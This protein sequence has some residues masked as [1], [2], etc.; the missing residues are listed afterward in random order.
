MWLSSFQGFFLGGGGIRGTLNNKPLAH[1]VHCY[2]TLHFKVPL[3]SAH[4]LDFTEARL[5]HYTEIVFSPKSFS[6]CP[7]AR[8]VL[9]N[10]ADQLGASASRTTRA[11]PVRATPCFLLPANVLSEITALAIGIS[12]LGFWATDLIHS[13]LSFMWLVLF[14]K[15]FIY[16]FSES[17]EGRDRGKERL[18]CE[19]NFNQLPLT[20]P[21]LGPTSQACILT[22]NRTS[23]LSACRTMPKQ[24]SYTSQ[25]YMTSFRSMRNIFP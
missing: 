18:V 23:N 9:C 1:S 5:E 22:G 2:G 6:R 12:G 10:E 17:G 8:L 11:T 7:S 3:C 20:H 15:D 24:L 14:F 13:F 19:R 4:N 16:L 25:G 21:Q